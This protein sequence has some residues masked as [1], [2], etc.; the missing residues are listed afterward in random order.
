MAPLTWHSGTKAGLGS[1]SW[2]NLW[3]NNFNKSFNK[4]ELCPAWNSSELQNCSSGELSSM[5]S[6]GTRWPFADTSSDRTQE[7]F[8]VGSLPWKGMRNMQPR[9]PCGLHAQTRPSVLLTPSYLPLLFI[10]VGP[11]DSGT[12]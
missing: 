8:Q 12:R 3:I 7:R 9:C 10:Q 5:P 2:E 1:D 6:P 4:A 11:R